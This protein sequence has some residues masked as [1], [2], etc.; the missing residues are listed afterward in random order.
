MN[1]A[2]SEELSSTGNRKEAGQ[3][4]DASGVRKLGQVANVT[5]LSMPTLE[6]GQGIS[7]PRSNPEAANARAVGINR[8]LKM[9]S[10]PHV[11]PSS[12]IVAMNAS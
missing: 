9:E 6:I 7:M 5:V 8:L 12:L 11:A 3:A 4:H 2:K 10:M 1:A